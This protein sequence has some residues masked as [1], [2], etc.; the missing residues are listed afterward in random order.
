MRDAGA[1]VVDTRDKYAF[2]AGH[3]PGAINIP[4]GRHVSTWAGWLLPY[5]K[6]LV[7]LAPP[8]QIETLVRQL[9]RVGLDHIAG[10]IPALEGYAPAELETVH[11]ISASEAYALWQ[12]G[13]AM[14]LDV[15]GAS[16]YKEMHIPGAVNIHAGRVLQSQAHIPR[17]QPVIVH[18]LS[19]DRSSIAVSALMAHGYRN[20][21]NLTDGILA[22]QQQGYP[23]EC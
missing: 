11:Q 3:L 6:P 14:I 17:D 18:C 15:R 1:I 12:R 9:I 5:D 10:Y 19:G 8:E 4:A 7:L 21:F 16:E 20:L 22:W 2:A 23:L 13:E